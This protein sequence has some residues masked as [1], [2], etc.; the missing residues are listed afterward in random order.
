MDS[1]ERT[2]SHI[3]GRVVECSFL[4]GKIKEFFVSWPYNVIVLAAL[5]LIT[6]VI[7]LL[8]TKRVLFRS[9]TLVVIWVLVAICFVGYYAF[10]LYP[11]YLSV[12]YKLPYIQIWGCILVF[13]M[14]LALGG[15]VDNYLIPG[16]NLLIVIAVDNQS[17][18]AARR[19]K[20]SI[21]LAKNNIIKDDDKIILEILPFGILTDIKKCERYIKKP[22]TRADAIIYATVVDDGDEYAFVNFTSRINRR[23][24]SREERYSGIHNQALESQVRSKEWNFI[25]SAND[26]CNRTIAISRNLEEMLRM[27]IGSIY[28]MKHKFEEATLYTNAILPKGGIN[29]P[30]DIL[31]SRL[32]YFSYLSS[33]RELETHSQDIDGALSKLNYC[34]QRLPSTGNDTGYNKAVARVMFYK[35]DLTA[36]K[37][38]TRTFKDVKGEQWGYEL[39]MGFYAMVEGKVET[40]VRHYRHLTEKYKPRDLAEID[41]ALDFL[42]KQINISNNQRY[43]TLLNIAVSYL[44]LYK[45]IRAAKKN[46]PS[47]L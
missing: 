34:L 42:K 17:E 41:F 31:A 46:Q 25:N 7:W 16:K 3:G 39:N 9:K 20:T 18:K 2:V 38:Y 26:N 30:T 19:I 1:Q 36:S 33:A 14:V 24:F 27:Y 15:C 6:W 12:Q 45:N 40:F 11:Q 37:K 23:R 13:V 28:L 5:F 21:K 44:Y 10:S 35:D 4:N 29:N 22:Y 47:L 43:S 8:S 32:F